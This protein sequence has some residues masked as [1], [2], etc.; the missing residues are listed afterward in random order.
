MRPRRALVLA[1]IGL[2]LVACTS[3]EATR[4][5]AGGP[6][7]DVGNRGV[8][9]L[10]GGSQPYYATPNVLPNVRAGDASASASVK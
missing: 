4:A 6:G 1:A 9:E 2:G 10:H 5:R 7:A 8:G 3:P